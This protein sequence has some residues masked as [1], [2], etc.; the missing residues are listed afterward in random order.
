MNAV[1]VT[2]ERSRAGPVGAL[3]QVG[4]RYVTL[5]GPDVHLV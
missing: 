3:G 4:C 1:Q 2:G 5:T